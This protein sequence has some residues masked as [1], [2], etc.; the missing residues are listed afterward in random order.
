MQ[1]VLV[2]D[3]PLVRRGLTAILSLDPAINVLGEAT[4]SKEALTLFQTATPDL[5]I[6]D[7]RLANES[8]L[9]LI[10]EAKQ[11]GVLV[12][13]SYLLHLRK[14]ATLNGRRK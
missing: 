1:I 12:N 14:S 6:V 4:N 9:D 2:D 5:A 3:H 7:L 8:G 11:Q 10:V 13:S